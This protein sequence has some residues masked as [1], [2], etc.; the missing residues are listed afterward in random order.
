MEFAFLGTQSYWLF[1]E[2]TSAR[3]YH[4]ITTRAIV[5]RACLQFSAAE[6]RGNR[7]VCPVPGTFSMDSRAKSPSEYSSHWLKPPSRGIFI[8]EEIFQLDDDDDDDNSLFY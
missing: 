6:T 8:E 4:R 5:C 1:N 7:L 3:E 2:S